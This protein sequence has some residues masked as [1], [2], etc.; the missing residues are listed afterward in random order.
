MNYLIGLIIGVVG[1]VVSAAVY[2]KA[3]ERFECWFIGATLA[4]MA[5]AG[6]VA[7]CLWFVQKRV[8]L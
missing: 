3:R 5:Y 2:R 6:V 1:L 8:L 7:L 4:L